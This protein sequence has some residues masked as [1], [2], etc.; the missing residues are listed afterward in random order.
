MAQLMCAGCVRKFGHSWIPWQDGET[1]HLLAFRLKGQNGAV[2]FA[3]RLPHGSLLIIASCVCPADIRRGGMPR[4]LI[5]CKSL[6]AGELRPQLR[7]PPD[8]SPFRPLAYRSGSGGFRY[9]GYLFLWM[10]PHGSC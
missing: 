9:G 6:P 1:E 3:E 4:A 8:K 10:W 5:R 7:I 2:G